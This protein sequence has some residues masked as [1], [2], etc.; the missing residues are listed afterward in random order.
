[1]K[2]IRFIFS[3]ENLV[4]SVMLFA[5]TGCSGLQQ[6]KKETKPVHNEKAWQYFSRGMWDEFEFRYEDALLNYYMASS[7][8]STNSAIFLAIAENEMRLEVYDVALVYYNRALKFSPDDNAILEKKATVLTK[9]E[10]FTEAY[11]IYKTLLQL[12]PGDKYY[13]FMIKNLIS[14][15]KIPDEERWYY[16]FLAKNI[17]TVQMQL[18]L[19][20]YYF[21]NEKI[22]SAQE[23]LEKLH[24]EEPENLEVSLSLIDCYNYRGWNEQAI[25]MLEKV[26]NDHS[27]MHLLYK[28]LELYNKSD[29][30]DKATTFLEK[31]LQKNPTS[32]QVYILLADAY[33]RKDLQ[34]NSLEI[35]HQYKN[36][37]SG[38]KSSFYYELS[39]RAYLGKFDQDTTR[40][41]YID[42]I[43]SILKEGLGIYPKDLNLWLLSVFSYTETR[44]WDQALSVL[45]KAE[46]K[47]PKSARLLTIHS[48]ILFTQG[49]NE[50]VLPVLKRLLVVEPSNKTAI[51]FLANYY[52]EQEDYQKADS[53]YK[54]GITYYPEEPLLLNNYA[55]SL[56]VRNIRLDTALQYINLAIKLEPENAAY[57]D[58]KGWI[59]YQLGKYQEA[60][61]Y[62]LQAYEKANNDKEVLEHL[63]DV[64]WQLGEKEEARRIWKLA[65][66]QAPDDP[67]LVN[68]LKRGLPGSQ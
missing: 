36:R 38:Q 32:K 66:E 30:N 2:Y 21:S 3:V 24:N 15:L 47:F 64:L 54:A 56:A 4:L 34:D 9:L 29:E 20:K 52:Q 17:P 59:L 60:Y 53:L 23:I 40:L 51:S 35:L 39:A 16:E 19:A 63:G 28:L 42:S 61:Q 7:F 44:D 27:D 22:A 12:Y 50:E 45:K 62:I 18:Q 25:L 6:V 31:Y 37:E 46:P 8:D 68:K 67:E 43:R 33:L 49:K 1:M 58:T 55:Y 10:K 13:Q 5:L 48:Q 57:L 41:A 14:I 65:I 11:Q 26:L